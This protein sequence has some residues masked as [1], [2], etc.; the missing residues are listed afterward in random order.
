MMLKPNYSL[1]LYHTD[2]YN[3]ADQCLPAKS[4]VKTEKLLLTKEEES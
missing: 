3:R 2:Q 1:D 4:L